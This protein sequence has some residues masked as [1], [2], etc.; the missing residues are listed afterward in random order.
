MKLKLTSYWCVV[1]FLAIAAVPVLAQFE[2][3]PDQFGDSQSSS[4]N[5]AG[6]SPAAGLQQ[7]IAL[8]TSLLE[9]YHHQI[10]DQVALV[11]QSWQLLISPEGSADEAGESIA[12]SVNQKRLGALV[13]FLEDPIRVAEA[14]LASLETRQ[15]A[16]MSSAKDHPSIV[17]HANPQASAL[18]ASSPSSSLDAMKHGRPSSRISDSRTN[19]AETVKHTIALNH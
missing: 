4:R 17:R 14:N 2:V 9:R 1:L 15:A 13:Q 18:M 16:L 7:Q 12:L 11:E 6:F 8:Q 19:D 10:A 3:T 5:A